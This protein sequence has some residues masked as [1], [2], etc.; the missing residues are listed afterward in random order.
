MAPTKKEKMKHVDQKSED[1]IALS[2]TKQK[3]FSQRMHEIN[4]D[5]KM[6]CGT[7][8]IGHIPRGFYEN[9]IR[10]YFSQF[11]TV[12]KVRLARSKKTG[13]YK[14]YGYIQF[15]SEDVAKIAAE[16]MNNYLMFDRLL[17]CQF[18]PES[19]LH[20]DLWKGANKKFV[21]LNR[22][23]K[24]KIRHNKLRSKDELKKTA[25]R[26]IKK[27]NKRRKTFLDL[28]IQYEFPGYAGAIKKSQ[29]AKRLSTKSTKLAD[30]EK[31]PR[32]AKPKQKSIKK[33][34]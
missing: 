29:K 32:T 10:A 13:G 17:K 11:G 21:W 23:L 16:A 4:G 34:E 2:A 18:V 15:A 20:P 25:D 8:Y 3:E 7:M 12:N 33:M 14:G 30:K 19:S 22:R 1:S 24:E 31:T 5:Q 26:L 28:G 27:D 6:T 9:E